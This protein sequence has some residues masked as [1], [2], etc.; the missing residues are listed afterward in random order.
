MR[1]KEI[2]CK[3]LN[4]GQMC[5]LKTYRVW[6]AKNQINRALHFIVEHKCTIPSSELLISVFHY[7]PSTVSGSYAS[8][9]IAT[10]LVALKTFS[11]SRAPYT[12]GL[13]TSDLPSCQI[14][15]PLVVMGQDNNPP[16]LQSFRNDCPICMQEAMISLLH[17]T[18]SCFQVAMI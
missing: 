1:K 4:E 6:T 15:T 13:G 17:M 16:F 7:F 18:K 11:H 9:P 10:P 5:I 8:V 2:Q 12:M 3:E 14:S